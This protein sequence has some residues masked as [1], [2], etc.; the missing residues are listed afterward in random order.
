MPPNSANL[1][2]ASPQLHPLAIR[3][4]CGWTLDAFAR[5]CQWEKYETCSVFWQYRQVTEC[6]SQSA[7]RNRGQIFGKIFGNDYESMP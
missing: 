4:E 1:F 3:T 7:Q 5:Q 2:P 6:E